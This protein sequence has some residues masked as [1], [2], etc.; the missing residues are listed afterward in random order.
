MENF[1]LPE[2]FSPDKFSG[3]QAMGKPTLAHGSK[4][5]E[6]LG[7]GKHTAAISCRPI[8]CRLSA[9]HEPYPCRHLQATRTGAAAPDCLK[10]GRP[11]TCPKPCPLP[12]LLSDTSPQLWGFPIHQALAGHQRHS[13]ILR[14][15]FFACPC[16]NPTGIGNSY[17]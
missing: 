16:E 8:P 17:A 7:A 9:L 3:R 1:G 5:P 14:R 4:L 6:N 15:A 11:H 12:S 2:N 10:Q 13:A